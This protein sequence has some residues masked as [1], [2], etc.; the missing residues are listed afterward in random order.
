MK[1]RS[2]NKRLLRHPIGRRMM[3]YGEINSQQGA[4]YVQTRRGQV[5]INKDRRSTVKVIIP[6]KPD[7][8]NTR[9]V[10]WNV[11]ASEI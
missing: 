2:D 7:E 1:R 4:V 10:V 8:I 5:M 3:V 11:S 9:E 6:R